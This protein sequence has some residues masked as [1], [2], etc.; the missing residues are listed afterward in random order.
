MNKKMYNRLRK[1]T[2]V[3]KGNIEDFILYLTEETGEISR[4]YLEHK[5]L[6]P[7]KSSETVPQE[8]CD[9]IICAMGLIQKYNWEYGEMLEYLDKKLQKYEK[10]MNKQ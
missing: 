5:K 2:K 7:G 10:R 1:C 4:S 8:A 6:K 9:A 3:D